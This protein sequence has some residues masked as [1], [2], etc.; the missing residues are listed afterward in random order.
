MMTRS[1]AIRCFEKWFDSGCVGNIMF[2]KS[3]NANK[4]DA[5]SE[6]TIKLW[7]M[8]AGDKAKVEAVFAALDA[9]K[10]EFFKDGRGRPDRVKVTGRP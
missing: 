8:S 1:E 9:E 5:V 3:P 2:F 10:L 4:C 7:E 6:E